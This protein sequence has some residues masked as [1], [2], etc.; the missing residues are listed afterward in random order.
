MQID[1]GTDCTSKTKSPEIILTFGLGYKDRN[2][3][4]LEREILEVIVSLFVNHLVG[5]IPFNE[6]LFHL[7]DKT[8]GTINEYKKHEKETEMKL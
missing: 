1:P 6:I 3:N 7:L 5:I 8:N 2:A 4:S